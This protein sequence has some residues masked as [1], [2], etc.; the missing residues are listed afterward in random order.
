VIVGFESFFE[1]ELEQ[2][3][4]NSDVQD[5]RR[6]MEVLNRLDITCFATVILNPD[7]DRRDF[8][9]LEKELKDLHIHFV[10]LQPLTPLPGTRMQAQEESLLLSRTDFPRWDLAHLS[11]RPTRLSIPDYYREILGL[12]HRV[13]FQPRVLVRYLRTHKPKMLWKMIRGSGRVSG[14]YR[15]KIEEAQRQLDSISGEAG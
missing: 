12:Y 5:N 6:A 11:I 10:N 15:N 8:V 4:K 3:A 2:Y 9:R 13:L 7:W 1:E 14:Q